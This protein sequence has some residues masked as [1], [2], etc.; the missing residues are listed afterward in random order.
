MEPD[1]SLPHL[2]APA[3]CPYPE[4]DQSNPRLPIQLP[5]AHF[6]Y[7]ISFLQRRLSQG[8]SILLNTF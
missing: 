8:I 3:T 7:T 2:Q 6:I 5:E 4:P 1:G